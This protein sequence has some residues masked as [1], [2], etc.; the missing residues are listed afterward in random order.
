MRKYQISNNAQITNPKY[1]TS[2]FGHWNLLENCDFG[3]EYSLEVG[4]WCLGFSN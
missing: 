4:A 2:Y 3:F 1:K